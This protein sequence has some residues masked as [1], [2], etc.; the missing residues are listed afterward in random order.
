MP[1]TSTGR[2]PSPHDVGAGRSPSLLS[3]IKAP[4]ATKTRHIGDFFVQPD[5]PHKQYGPGDV[6]TGS[7]ILKVLRPL[8]VTHITVC[9]HGFV[10]V[11]KAA[12]TPGEGY[13][14][15]TGTSTPGKTMRTGYF[16]NG[17]ASLFVDEVALCG[18][19]RLGEGTYQFGFELVFPKSR[20]P[21]SINVSQRLSLLSTLRLTIVP[22][23]AR[24]SCVHD[25]LYSDEAHSDCAY[26]DM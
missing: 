13:K 11:Y 21:S 8:R 18:E 10:Q 20:Q 26:H 22:V 1:S 15:Y 9:L 24:D 14:A 16:G 3:R 6:V 7:I 23:R 19:G 2:S 25:N 17:F 4:F 12:N 5:D